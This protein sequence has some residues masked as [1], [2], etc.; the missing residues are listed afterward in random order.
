MNKT[1]LHAIERSAFVVILD[2]EDQ[3]WDPVISYYFTCHPISFSRMIRRAWTN[4]QV[5]Y[6]MEKPMIGVCILYLL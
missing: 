5:F 4:G 1:S 6:F 3:R 2:E